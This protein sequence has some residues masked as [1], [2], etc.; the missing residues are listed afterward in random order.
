VRDNT[1]PEPL[2]PM[3]RIGPLATAS[4]LGAPKL[5]SF[6]LGATLL[7]YAGAVSAASLG[8][9]STEQLQVALTG[10]LGVGGVVGALC[11]HRIITLSRAGD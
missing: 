10:I 3:P 6:A 9:M 1:Q 8:V 4:P 2:R 5:V 7:A 11:A